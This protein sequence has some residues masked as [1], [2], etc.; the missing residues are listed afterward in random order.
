MHPLGVGRAPIFRH[1]T[2]QG[3]GPFHHCLYGGDVQIARQP[4]LGIDINGKKYAYTACRPGSPTEV[5]GLNIQAGVEMRQIGG[6]GYVIF[7]GNFETGAITG[8]R[9]PLSHPP[10][11]ARRRAYAGM[12]GSAWNFHHANSEPF[13][14]LNPR[15][16]CPGSA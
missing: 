9:V 10:H 6:R 11:D 12:A 1:H 2:P 13:M 5:T 3:L 15:D 14:S 16:G 4:W 7:D 8:A